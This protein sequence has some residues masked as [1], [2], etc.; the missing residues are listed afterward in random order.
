[1]LDLRGISDFTDYFV[2]ASGTS[3]RQLQSL[4]ANV[5]EHIKADGNGDALIEG[6]SSS[7]WIVLDFG[8]VVVHLLLPEKRLYYQLEELWHRGKVV[9]RVQ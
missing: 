7:G 3:D 2:I 8:S 4:A 5:S 1:M 9:L 6:V